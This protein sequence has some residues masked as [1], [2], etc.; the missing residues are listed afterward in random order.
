[1][2]PADS[3][4]PNGKLR[5]LYE[6][7]PLSFIMEQAGGKASTSRQACLDIVPHQIH[8]R[9]PV[10]FS[11]LFSLVLS[12]IVLGIYGK[13]TRCYRIRKLPQR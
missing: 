9:V 1:M 3:K 8:Q 6:V 4:S 11:S 5:Y 2:Y 7:A 13:S 10:R 12:F